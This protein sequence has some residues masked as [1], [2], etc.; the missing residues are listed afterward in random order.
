KNKERNEDVHH[1][2]NEDDK[3]DDSCHATGVCYVIEEDEVKLNSVTEGK[4][5]KFTENDN[6][7]VDDAPNEMIKCSFEVQKKYSLNECDVVIQDENKD[8]VERSEHTLEKEKKK[9]SN[10]ELRS[11]SLKGDVGAEVA[12]DSQH[13]IE[14]IFKQDEQIQS[15]E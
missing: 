3:V 14:D 10:E 13:T 7:L 8:S 15:A 12:V 6:V 1:I 2:L 9:I 4:G 11:Q 5:V